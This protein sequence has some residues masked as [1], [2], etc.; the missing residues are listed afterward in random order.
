M[1]SVSLLRGAGALVLSFL[2]FFFPISQVIT[3]FSKLMLCAENRKEM[4]DW[5]SALKSV[6]KWENYEVSCSFTAAY[7][8]RGATSLTWRLAA[9]VH[10]P[11]T[12]PLIG[13]S[14]N[15]VT[16][17]APKGF[18]VQ[19]GALLWHAQLVRLL[20]CSPD[21]LQCV[22]RGSLWGHLPR[23]VL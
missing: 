19:Y 18:S 6:Q 20:P 2:L 3:P 10:L 17:S 12:I 11:A 13:P 21:L 4:E 8:N 1:P 5:I 9:A 7:Q 23:P 15:H 14:Y 16:L 22:S